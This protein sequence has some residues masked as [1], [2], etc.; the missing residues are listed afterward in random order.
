MSEN[1]VKT[2]VVTG[3]SSA[4]GAA[5]ARGLAERGYRLVLVGRDE[6]GL[7]K[8]AAEI[9]RQRRILGFSSGMSSSN[10]KTSFGHGKSSR[11]FITG[12]AEIACRI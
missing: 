6:A 4:F 2:A 11:R 3:A 12:L 5:Y 8:H 7:S 10:R 1:A 9:T